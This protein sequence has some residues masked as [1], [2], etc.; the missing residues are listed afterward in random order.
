MDKLIE[1]L[2]DINPDNDY[3]KEDKLIDGG[4]LDSL[5]ILELVS[6]LEDTYGIEITATELVPANF[7]SAAA[8][9]SMIQRLQN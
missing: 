4:L 1:I 9:W 7:N 5:S 8:M 3:M 2:E 6:T